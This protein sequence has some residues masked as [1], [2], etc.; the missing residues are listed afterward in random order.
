[1]TLG[2]CLNLCVLFNINGQDMDP[3]I[4]SSLSPANTAT[5]IPPVG[6]NFSITFD[7]TISQQDC[8]LISLFRT[9]DGAQIAQFETFSSGGGT[10]RSIPFDDIV[11]EP[12]TT[13]HIL[14][15]N[16]TF[17]DN[18][19]N[20]FAGISSSDTWSFTTSSGETTAPMSTGFSPSNGDMSA[21]ITT[22]SFSIFFDEDVQSVAGKTFS[23]HLSSDGSIVSQSTTTSS[24]DFGTTRSLVFPGFS[25]V[26]ET[27]Y[28]IN[29][30]AGAFQD[31]FGNTY[32]GISDG[33]TWSFTIEAGESD[34]PLT[35]GFTPSNASTNIEVNRTFYSLSFDEGVRQIGGKTISI[36]RSSDNTVIATDILWESGFFSDGWN[37]F[38]NSD[39][40]LEPATTYHMVVE[41]GSYVDKFGNSFVGISDNNTW[42]FTTESSETDLPIISS[43]SPSNGA[44]GVSTTSGFSVTFN[45][46]VKEKEG[47]TFSLFRTSDNA[48]IAESTLL[49]SAVF[50]TSHGSDIENVVLEP[51]TSYYLLV[52]AGSFEDPFGNSFAG[53]TESD[54]WRFT[55]G[56]ADTSA[57][58]ISCQDPINGLIDF[59]VTNRTFSFSTNESVRPVGDKKI[60][61]VRASDGVLIDETTTF[62]STFF[63]SFQNFSFGYTVLEAST[64]YY[65]TI[66]AG[67]YVDKSGNQFAGISD[68]STWA[69]TTQAAESNPPLISSL[70]PGNGQT[71]VSVLS[72][73]YS[74][75][76]NESVR[77][78]GGK[79]ISLLRST[80][81]ALIAQTTTSE[82]NFFGLSWNFSFGSTLLQPSTTYYINIESGSY[83]DPFG[84]AFAGVSDNMSWSFTTQAGETDP[85]QIESIFPSTAEPASILTSSYTVNFD[86]AVRRVGCK[87]IT[88][89]RSSDGAIVAQTVTRDEGSFSTSQNLFLSNGQLDPSTTYHLNIEEGAFLD[90]F[91]NP[92]GA[93]ADSETWSFTTGVAE[94]TAPLFFELSP[95]NGSTGVSLNQ[96]FYRIVFD[97]SVRQIA[98]KSISLRRASDNELI[99]E[100]V[101]FGNSN[102]R[103]IQDFN[104][105]VGMLEPETTYY[106][107]VEE[108]AFEDV[109]GNAFAGITGSTTW[110]FTTLSTDAQVPLLTGT[111]PAN[112]SDNFSITQNSF[113]ISFDEYVRQLAGFN[114][115]LRRTN[116]DVVVAELITFETSFS[117]SHFFSF[118]NLSL[119]AGT[120]YYIT[121]DANAFE[122]FFGNK[123]TG[124]ADKITWTFT[125]QAPETIPP[126]LTFITPST[127]SLGNDIANNSY[128]INFDESVKQVA[129]KSVQ[130][131][132]S[133]NDEVVAQTTTTDSDFFTSSVSFLFNDLVLETS[134]SY[135]ITIETGAVVDFFG[136][137]FAGITDKNTWSFTTEC[138]RTDPPVALVLT[139]AN[140]STDLSP[141]PFTS[142]T[143]NFDRRVKQVAGNTITLNRLEDNSVALESNN[144]DGSFE[145]FHTVFPGVNLASSTTYFI[146][147]PAGTFVDA[148]GNEF[149]GILTSEG[150][151][152]TTSNITS[153]GEDIE[154]GLVLYPV[155]VNTLLSVA[156]NDFLIDRLEVYS[157]NGSVV[158]ERDFNRSNNVEVDLSTLQSGIYLIKVVDTRNAKQYIQR[159]IK[160]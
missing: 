138:A 130:I 44:I 72:G 125:T 49:N 108:G 50:S 115:S 106:L 124:F 29:V 141:F 91:G 24:N 12:S 158:F 23:I 80:D 150:W 57:P 34:A 47:G 36:V 159:I 30:D 119:D 33:S 25:P 127:G 46:S 122:D 136:N 133:D 87:M 103:S 129:G 84:N 74:I 142:F 16:G 4:I 13:Y 65:I 2:L 116:D 58:L 82:L 157:L 93:I 107:E 98:D 19:G 112:G 92:S 118:E 148:F 110:A 48:L 144:F 59:S 9:S 101:T 94:T 11:L 154:S 39:L 64:T 88:L 73:N 35:T 113:R 53:I 149:G 42:S 66:E 83:L 54:V 96:S 63:S 132:R 43:L 146:L 1:M 5:D 31:V 76:F 131:L 117:T 100:F 155:P 151:S 111:S 8:K 135:Y 137:E 7:E 90:V 60:G 97:E 56:E 126:L 120:E 17:L 153:V 55:T 78:L 32:A 41:A 6:Q 61:I 67:A 79:T 10:S 156:A 62:E 38:F 143:I 140:G 75:Q 26:P 51:N 102:L 128:R 134:T 86:E 22:T 123:F 85:P 69:F 145:F 89:I 18:S 3:P 15:P 95:F 152:F 28:Y 99:V 37:I 21:S 139:P 27:T 52:S 147:V 105:S 81:N 71:G 68:G 20:A 70:T 14:I 40:L 121:V 160:N 104:L 114:I 77:Q 45:E 109:F